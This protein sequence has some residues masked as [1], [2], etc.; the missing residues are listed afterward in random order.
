MKWYAETR[1]TAD[2]ALDDATFDAIADALADIEEADIEEAEEA[3]P[4]I[5]DADL[6]ASLADG[7]VTSSMV[8]EAG[9]LDEAV[10]RA[11]AVMRAAVHAAGCG[12]AGWADGLAVRPAGDREPVGT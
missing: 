9:S 10:T 11:L 6:G 12:T 8:V 4:C 7:W 2:R 5:E 3:D 1:V